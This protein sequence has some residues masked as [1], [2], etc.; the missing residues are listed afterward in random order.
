[1][2]VVEGRPDFSIRDFGVTIA[3]RH[4]PYVYSPIGALIHKVA[5]VR[6]HWYDA[7]GDY[8]ERLQ[9]PKL[10]I[11]TICHQHFFPKK[12]GKPWAVMCEL[13]RPNACL[14]GPCH[15]QLP[16]WG[17]DSNPTV[18]RDE[19]R[20]LLGCVDERE[21][22]NIEPDTLPIGRDRLALA[23]VMIRESR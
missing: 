3:K 11:V 17:R 9:H 4:P 18:T 19:A 7:K 10:I 14:C 2:I 6:M 16:T 20:R 12:H 15:G 23:G 1:M 22:E 8:L 13:P 5:L 21:R